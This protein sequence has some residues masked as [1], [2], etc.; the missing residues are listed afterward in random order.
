[1]RNSDY[2]PAVIPAIVLAAGR[3]TRMG[4][5]K[6][7]LPVDDRDTFLTRIIRTFNEAM[8]ADV[9]VVLGYEASNVSRTVGQSGL[10]PRLVIN[11][12]FDNG[13]F[14]SL[15]VGLNAIDRPGVMRHF[16]CR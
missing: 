15:L 16:A 1:M 7:T 8:V 9:T 12:A 5:L 3:S 13:Q 2:D 6:A 10:S 14:S 11:D 4:R